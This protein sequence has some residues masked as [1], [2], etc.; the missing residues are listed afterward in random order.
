MNRHSLAINDDG[1]SH[2]SGAGGAPV[3][4]AWPTVAVLAVLL[5]AIDGFWSVSLQGAVGHIGNAQHPFAAWLRDSLLVLPLLLLAVLAAVVLANRLA[6]R[7]ART[8]ARTLPTVLLVAGLAS[9]PGVGMLAL[10]GWTDYLL[11]A[12]GL[13]MSTSMS[14]TCDG[15]CL[16]DLQQTA[17]SIQ[18]KALGIGVLLLLISNLLAVAWAAALLG[19]RLATLPR[20]RLRHRLRLRLRLRLRRRP[21]SDALQLT[22]IAALAGSAIIHFA[23]VPE[24]LAEWRLAGVFFFEL[25]LAQL[26]AAVAVAVSTGRGS[27]Y[28]AAALSAIPLGVWAVSRTVGLPLGPEPGVPEPLGA[29]DLTVALLEA[30]CLAVVLARL[31]SHATRAA[32]AA[33]NL[34]ARAGSVC[35][36]ATIAGLGLAAVRLPVEEASPAMDHGTELVAPDNADAPSDIDGGL[37]TIP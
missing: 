17:A 28:A 18:L 32:L 12:D 2:L 1:A 7:Q 19:G 13:G 23:I 30:A 35:V 36:I 5:A 3:R 6:E 20:S 8:S 25:G 27:L 16:A 31:R 10:H 26:T 21:P 22:I 33:P 14:G 37:N 24:H 9:L 4:V 29:A 34:L 11:Q 15:N